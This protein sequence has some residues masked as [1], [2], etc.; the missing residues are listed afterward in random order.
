ML[1]ILLTIIVLKG[2]PQY[3]LNYRVL[4]KNDFNYSFIY[5]KFYSF[6]SRLWS[7][8]WV[9]WT[10]VVCHTFVDSKFYLFIFR[11][12][13]TAVLMICCWVELLQ[14]RSTWV[15]WL[16]S[17]VPASGLLVCCLLP[18]LSCPWEEPAYDSDHHFIIATYSINCCSHILIII[19]QLAH[20][21]KFW[22][23]TGF[24]GKVSCVKKIACTTQSI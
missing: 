9:T 2:W 23:E 5:V 4:P 13:T 3:K 14:G 24:K 22:V 17:I 19:L 8:P 1:L 18:G 21:N 10:G 12:A 11:I 16:C 6:C 7:Y 20:S 15:T